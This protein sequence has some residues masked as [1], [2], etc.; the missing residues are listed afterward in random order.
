MKTEHYM[1]YICAGGLVPAFTCCLVD[2]S[3]SESLQ[4]S[5]LV[6]LLGLPVESLPSLGS[7]I[8]LPTIPL[9]LPELHPLFVCGTIHWFQSAPG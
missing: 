7:V 5:R 2:G 8:L 9:R 3:V 6:D 1:C 4:E